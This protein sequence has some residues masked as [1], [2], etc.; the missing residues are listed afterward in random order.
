MVATQPDGEGRSRFRPDPAD[1]DRIQD[2]ITGPSGSVIS[3]VV[4]VAVVAAVVVTI[5]I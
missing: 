2:W 5:A 4:V 3:L 1:V